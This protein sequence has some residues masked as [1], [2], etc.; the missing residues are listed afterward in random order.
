[1]RVEEKA[2]KQED[3]NILTEGRVVAVAENYIRK[4]K[5]AGI[6]NRIGI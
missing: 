3:T 1:M 5:T 2:F 6:A 4:R